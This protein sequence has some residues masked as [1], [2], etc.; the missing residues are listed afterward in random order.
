MTAAVQQTPDTRLQQDF[1]AAMGRVAGSVVVVTTQDERGP[2]G[3]TVSAFTSLSIEPPMV[4]VALD[5]RSSLLDR[6]G[7]GSPLG[8][9]VLAA[10][11]DQVA[12][13]FATKGR[14]R[15][16]DV[17]WAS[18]HGA[19]AL[20]DRHAWIAGRVARL[21][22]GGDHVV[23]LVDVV[24]A[25]EGGQAPLVYWQRTFGTHHAF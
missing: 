20:A 21:V 17:E 9:N 12:L 18:D 11:Q 16:E 24:H 5:V 22:D 19:P 6:L 14:D 8:V 2:H 10:H 15:F 25:E 23:V 7:V 1:R 13:R 4:L 3:T